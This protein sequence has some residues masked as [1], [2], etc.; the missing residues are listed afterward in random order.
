MTLT[1]AIPIIGILNSSKML[2]MFGGDIAVEF[3]VA[4]ITRWLVKISGATV[5][6]AIANF[7]F[8][9]D[10]LELVYDSIEL[11]PESNAMVM[12][13]YPQKLIIKSQSYNF[14]STLLGLA[15]AGSYDIPINF[16]LA[17]MKQ[18][19]FYFTQGLGVNT[20]AIGANAIGTVAVGCA[21]LTF[22]GINPN[23]T[24]IVFVTNG[25]TYPQRPIKLY[26]PAECY[27]QIRKAFGSIYS[28]QFCGSIGRAEFLRRDTT[29]T[30]TYFG[31]MATPAN[32]TYLG[33][34]FYLAIDTELIN[35]N[36]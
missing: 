30:T 3:T 2:P 13:A 28:N 15:G 19:F 18:L 26:N 23:G 7:T 35:T 1:F 24:D 6:T 34:K 14:G 33:N 31:S 25:K 36:K 32:L 21:D 20:I 5:N 10:N 27:M 12:S 16:K 4:D 29:D 22:G 17:S 9:L 11:S 8:V